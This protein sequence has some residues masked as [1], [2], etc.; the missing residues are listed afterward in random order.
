MMSVVFVVL[1]IKSIQAGQYDD[2]KS[3]KWRI[4]FDNKETGK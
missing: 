4:L 1:C 3:P 2:L